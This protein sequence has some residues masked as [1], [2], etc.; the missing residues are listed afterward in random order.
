MALNFCS[1]CV[2]PLKAG[3]EPR[4]LGR[5]L[6]AET[7]AQNLISL[8]LLICFDARAVPTTA[9]VE[10]GSQFIGVSSLLPPLGISEIHSGFSGFSAS[11]SLPNGHA[12]PEVTLGVIR[13]S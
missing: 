13:L 8:H 9:L 7:P 5:A 1:S 10:V 11:T 4:V 3:I 6:P 2:Y 12:R